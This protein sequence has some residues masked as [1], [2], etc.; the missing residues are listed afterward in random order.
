M[1]GLRTVQGWTREEFES[2]SGCT[3]NCF[4]EQLDVLS[5]RGLV[6]LADDAVAPTERGLTFWNDIAESL[7]FAPWI[8]ISRD[9]M[10]YYRLCFFDTE[11]YPL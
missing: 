8:C 7:V 2:A 9:M 5:E 11:G 10:V 4:K 3:W 1:M 6:T